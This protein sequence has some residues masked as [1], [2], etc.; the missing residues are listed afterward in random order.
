MKKELKFIA[1]H[2][3]PEKQREKAIEESGEYTQALKEYTYAL[4]YEDDPQEIEYR[5][6]H[7]IEEAADTWITTWHFLHQEN[8]WIEFWGFVK[9][10]IKRTIERIKDGYYDSSL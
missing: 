9:A 3:G 10:K 5:R 8:A 7:A 4:K 1:N 6:K 2:F